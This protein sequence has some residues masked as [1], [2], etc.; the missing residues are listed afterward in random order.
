MKHI[1]DEDTLDGA[2]VHDLAPEPEDEK[3][4]TQ[5]PAA[6]KPRKRKKKPNAEPQ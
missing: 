1:G 6:R 2:D 4:A 3:E 5:R